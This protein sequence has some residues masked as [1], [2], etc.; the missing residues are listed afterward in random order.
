MISGVRLGNSLTAQLLIIKTSTSEFVGSPDAN[1]SHE[2]EKLRLRSASTHDLL[3]LD[4][5]YSINT[6]GLI[7]LSRTVYDSSEIRV[8]QA[9]HQPVPEINGSGMLRKTIAR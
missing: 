7:D 4:S 6:V 2:R 5:R 9:L 8:I 3:H 1:N